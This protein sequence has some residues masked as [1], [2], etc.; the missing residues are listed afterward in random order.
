MPNSDKN[1][2]PSDIPKK[3]PPHDEEGKKWKWDISDESLGVNPSTKSEF[4]NENIWYGAGYTDEDNKR[5]YTGKHLDHEYPHISI[6]GKS[7]TL[8]AKEGYMYRLYDCTISEL[9]VE[10]TCMVYSRNCKVDKIT[11]SGTTSKARLHFTDCE[12]KDVT[13]VSKCNM[14][15]DGTTQFKE[16][17]GSA[18]FNSISDS[19]I[20]VTSTPEW[21]L[22]SSKQFNSISG[23]MV[24]VGGPSCIHQNSGQAMIS[25]LSDSVFSSLGQWLATAEKSGCTQ[26]AGNKI[27][28]GVSDSH[29]LT[30]NTKI[31]NPDVG[32]A[33]CEG[34]SKSTMTN[35]DGEF[36]I[37]ATGYAGS[38]SHTAHIGGKYEDCDVIHFHITDGSNCCINTELLGAP[39][40]GSMMET[41]S[42]D[43]SSLVVAGGKIE[44]ED[45]AAPVFKA[46]DCSMRF[47]DCETV[48]QEGSQDLSANDDNCISRYVH[49]DEI[50]SDI[51]KIWNEKKNCRVDVVGNKKIEA[52]DDD[53]CKMSDNSV[54]TMKYNCLDDKVKAKKKLFH[55]TDHSALSTERNGEMEADEEQALVAEEYA[56]IKFNEDKTIYSKQHEHAFEIKDHSKIESRKGLLEGKDSL[57]C[58]VMEDKSE[59]L[60]EYDTIKSQHHAI[61]MTE[62]KMDMRYPDVDVKHDGYHG[63][64][65]F[66]DCLDG[67]IKCMGEEFTL[68][69]CEGTIKNTLLQGEKTLEFQGK[70]SFYCY[71]LITRYINMQAKDDIECE[72]MTNLIDITGS[73]CIFKVRFGTCEGDISISAKEAWLHALDVNGATTIE[74]NI[75]KMFGSNFKALTVTGGQLQTGQL[76]AQ[77]TSYTSALGLLSSSTHTSLSCNGNYIMNEIGGG[78]ISVNGLAYYQ[79]CPDVLSLPYKKGVYS[80]DNLDVYAVNNIKMWASSGKVEIEAAL[81]I[82]SKAG[83]SIKEEAG[84]SIEEK[85]GMNISETAG[86]I[87][88]TMASRVIHNG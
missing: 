44:V 12:I 37:H 71:N 60:S 28:S 57:Y 43:R 26:T 21:T 55:I 72:K 6:H 81:D 35:I 2:F 73:D 14:H 45:N 76:T 25:G 69:E 24:M 32:G 67:R 39:G 58:I 17:D 1:P 16:P 15:F 19:S 86:G 11:G 8:K 5:S 78:S 7:G 38:E 61:Q 3:K 66:I 64:Q 48:H 52:L 31:N 42:S 59:M 34:M 65:S 30:V 88:S 82:L 10:G 20:T 33:L 87:A 70:N 63:G 77:T 84:M 80:S 50:K 27:F 41:G 13:G 23:S 9:I 22:S 85:A 75:C 4:D 46:T 49:C 18:Q 47:Y 83:M 79:N 29:I 53:M 54:M 56:N 68:S 40:A 62:S 74:A 51:K 36:V